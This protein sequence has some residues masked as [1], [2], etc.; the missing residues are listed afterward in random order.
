MKPLLDFNADTQ[1]FTLNEGRIKEIDFREL[2]LSQLF[3]RKS[4]LVILKKAISPDIARKIKYYYTETKNKEIFAKASKQGNHRIFYYLN[5][6]YRHPRFIRSLLMRALELKNR[7]FFYNNYY[8]T[9]CMSKKIDPSRYT[10]VSEIQMLHTW[11]SV[12]WYKNGESH[13]KHIDNYGELAAFI[14]LSKKGIDYTDGGLKIF[15]NDGSEIFADDHYDY[16]DFVLFDQ[17]QHYHE[18]LPVVHN[19]SQIGRISYYI[20]TIPPYYMQKVLT[21]EG[22]R[23]KRFYTDNEYRLLQKL[24]DRIMRPF[25]STK[26]HYSRVN[27]DHHIKTL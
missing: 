25:N 9:Y 13:Y 10:E 14:I 27:F 16:G 4:S 8:Q 12:Y 22:C 1:E 15:R 21:F 11:M 19:E 3:N 2:S 5:S 17:S 6:P 20:P 18:V 23:F 26:V 7:F 24:K